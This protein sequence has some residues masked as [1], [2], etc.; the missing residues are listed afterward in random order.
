V[1]ETHWLIGWLTATEH[2]S[3]LED[4][5]LFCGREGQ[6]RSDQVQAAARDDIVLRHLPKGEV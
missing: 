1:K 2:A 6:T 4:N 5:Y 3:R